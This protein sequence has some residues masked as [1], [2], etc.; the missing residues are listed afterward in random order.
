MIRRPPRSTP[1]YSSAA[2]DVYKRQV[3][4]LG[5]LEFQDQFNKKDLYQL[6]NWT[7]T[8][9]KKAAHIV[10]VSNFSK[11]EIERIYK[12]DPKKI[13]IGQTYLP[14]LPKRYPQ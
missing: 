9:I 14:T 7:K 6:I 5:Y 12:I 2:S 8:S 4:D 3:H 11:T 10:T 13:T 1:L